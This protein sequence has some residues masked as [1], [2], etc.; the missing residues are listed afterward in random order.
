MRPETTAA[1]ASDAL[2]PD[3]GGFGPGH[4]VQVEPGSSREIGFHVTLRAPAQSFTLFS[5]RLAKG[6]FSA[7][8]PRFL[9]RG[10]PCARPGY[11]ASPRA[12]PALLPMPCRLRE[13]RQPPRL[14]KSPCPS[15]LAR[16]ERRL[17]WGEPLRAS[18]RWSPST[19]EP[20]L[21]RASET[22][23][24]RNGSKATSIS[25]RMSR[26]QHVCSNTD[27]GRDRASAARLSGWRT[28]LSTLASMAHSERTEHSDAHASTSQSSHARGCL[29]AHRTGPSFIAPNARR[30]PLG[31]AHGARTKRGSRPSDDDKPT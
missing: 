14:R 7:A 16:T 31:G 10:R 3:F 12:E 27:S 2:P 5:N 22:R 25:N 6:R 8:A 17:C 20:R 13:H 9:E 29:G 11:A 4:S 28:D 24:L 21:E 18:Q 15:A 23:R 26:N 1:N 19:A 30:P